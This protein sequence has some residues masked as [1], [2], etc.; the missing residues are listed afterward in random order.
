MDRADRDS[1]DFERGASCIEVKAR[2]ASALPFVEIS[3]EFQLDQ[4][5][6]QNLFLAVVDVTAATDDYGSSLKEVIDH[7]RSRLQLDGEALEI[8]EERILAAG[9][10]YT[11]DYSDLSWSI[12][13]VAF[14]C[15]EVDFP[16]IRFSQLQDGISR[17]E[18]RL[19]LQHIQRFAT[20]WEQIAVTFGGQDHGSHA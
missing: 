10:L 9:S 3:S 8:F 19:S 14:F 2:R 16:A 12:G 6:L 1:Q 18:Y 13:D 17:V 11:D 15:V 20:G 7:V 5:S 4:L